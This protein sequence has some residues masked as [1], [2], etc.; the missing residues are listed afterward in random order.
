MLDRLW[1]KV[2]LIVFLGFSAYAFMFGAPFRTMDDQFSIVNNPL[3]RDTKHIKDIFIQGYFNDH[4]YYRPLVNLSFMAEY[5]FFKLTPFFYNLD[6]L[7]LHILN[8]FLV[9][10]LVGLLTG[11]IFIGFWVGLLFII[12][13]IH[14][15]AVS[16]ISGRAILMGASFVLT[17][18]ICFLLYD[19]E[20]KRR[21][22]LF[23]VCLFILGLL[24]KESSAVLPGVL[25]LYLWFKKKPLTS[26]W[27]FV[28][29]VGGYVFLRLSLGITQTFPW[30][31][32]FER[33]L[34]FVTFLRSL[35]T[36]L[37]LLFCPMGL[38]FDRSQRVFMFVMEG[39]FLL[40]LLV[41]GALGSILWMNRRRIK[42]ITA[43][44]LGWFVL[45]LFPVSQIVTTVGVAPGVISC[46]D[47]FL[48][49][50]SIPIFI[51][52]IE[53]GVSLW[54]I[55]Q[56]KN[57]VNTKVLTIAAGAF[58]IFL[59]LMNVEQN[60][61]AGNELAML[62]RS[63]Q[64]QPDNARVQSSLGLVYASRGEFDKA[65]ECFFQA[66]I[67]D[68]QNPRYRI[69]LAKSICDQGRYQECLDIYN[70]IQNP[71]SFEKL[72]KDN[73]EAALRLVQHAQILSK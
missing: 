34:G 15:E 31:S 25:F 47:H 52:L 33:V 13:P 62:K 27:P 55:N 38:H 66:V 51:I 29:V 8:T 61:Y 50:A 46:A 5:H 35:L 65:Q 67:K 24:C 60:I 9:W 68:A 53:A 17:A 70:Q 72:L 3:I 63:L 21:F 16:N 41:W 11:N 7:F 69:S 43:F 30:N 4:S 37:Y 45:E 23:S 19:K 42:M 73:K 49:L 39:E 48:Y 40:T 26:L 6:N 18:F 36:D 44:C 54:Q 20:E 71:G 22:L 1:F 64:M 58:F 59:F 2:L 12:H 32:L 57:W 10:V 14:T 28:G 56:Q